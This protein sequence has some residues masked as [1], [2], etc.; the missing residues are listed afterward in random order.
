MFW[1]DD[2][3]TREYVVPDDVVDLNFKINCTHLPLDH[4]YALHTAI[5]EVLPWLEDEPEAAIHLIHG[6]ESGNGW[7]RPEG[8]DE[9]IYPSRRTLFS[10]RTPNSRLEELKS[11]SGSTL[12]LDDI[13]VALSKPSVRPLSKL[14]TIF[15]RH[16][17]AENNED[18]ESFLNQT[19]TLLE[20]KNIRPKKMMS[21]RI[22]TMKFPDRVIYTR[23]LMLD[24]LDVKE[25]V[26]L[27]Q[28][29][30]GDGRLYGCGIFLPHKGID[31][32]NETQEK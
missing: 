15:A 25:S 32:V 16:L 10:I 21:G 29:G 12:M 31:A 3:Q 30:L 24:G 14:T 5:K 13:P 27:Q 28:E 8:P 2:K 17:I 4:A 22:H 19:L 1:N 18:E 7:I 23:S 26:K 20:E 9:V 11:L 6:A